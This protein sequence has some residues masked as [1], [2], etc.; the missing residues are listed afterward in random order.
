MPKAEAPNAA[1][2]PSADIPAS[3][4]LTFK[5]AKADFRENQRDDAGLIVGGLDQGDC[6]NERNRQ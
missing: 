4:N 6:A 3:R 1:Y 2:R 5:F